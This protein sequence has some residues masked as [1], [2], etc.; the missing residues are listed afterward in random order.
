MTAATA[1]IAVI[2]RGDHV[3]LANQ[4]PVP[5]R[6][7]GTVAEVATVLHHRVGLFVKRRQGALYLNTSLVTKIPRD[8]TRKF[9]Q[10]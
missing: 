1:P 6:Y 9:P 7:Q 3:R 2:A 4:V 8:E 5:S 10:R